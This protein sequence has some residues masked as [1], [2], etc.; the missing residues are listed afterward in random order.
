MSMSV[1][2]I[3]VFR[4]Y[5]RAM[6]L[7]WVRSEA[8]SPKQAYQ[9][10]R[11]VRVS[12]L[13]RSLEL[14]PPDIRPWRPG[15]PAPEE[16]RSVLGRWWSEGFEHVF[17]WRNGRLE[18][19]RVDAP[20]GKPPAVFAPTG[21]PDVLRTVSGRETGELLRLTRDAAGQVVTMHWATYRFTRV[22][23]TFDGVPAGEP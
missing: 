16:Y 13:A 6:P 9:Q 17:R 11:M 12:V 22:Q 1:T 15:P 5:Q 8:A 2:L 7:R 21:D 18:S 4:R 20:A 19:Q 3:V 23:E 10:T 14:D